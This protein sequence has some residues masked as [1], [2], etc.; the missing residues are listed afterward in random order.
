MDEC[1]AKENP[2]EYSIRLDRYFITH[3][4]RTLDGEV[5]STIQ[6]V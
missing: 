6:A 3:V 4:D 2:F 5:L 1:L